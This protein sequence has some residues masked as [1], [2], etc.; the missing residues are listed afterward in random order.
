MI[1]SISS[2]V[3]FILEEI[4]GNILYTYAKSLGMQRYYGFYI[5]THV[6]NPSYVQKSD[7]DLYS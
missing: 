4:E 5:C 1:G 6:N 2:V 7:F 3:Y